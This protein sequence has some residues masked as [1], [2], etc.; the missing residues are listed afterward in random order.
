M[1]P[2]IEDFILLWSLTKYGSNNVLI[3]ERLVQN[4]KGPQHQSTQN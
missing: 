3:V 1:C 2:L 4:K